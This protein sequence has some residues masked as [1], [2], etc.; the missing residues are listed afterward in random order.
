MASNPE[1]IPAGGRDKISVVVNTE[2]R[3][4]QRL[5]KHFTVMTNDPSRPQVDLIVAG[6]VN[7]YVKV[8]PPYIRLLGRADEDLRT[9][10]QIQP[11]KEHPFTIKKVSAREGENIRYELKPLGAD[12]AQGGYE[13]VVR[14]TRKDTGTYRDFITIETDLKE[15]P[16]LKIPVSGRILE[17]PAG[18]GRKKSK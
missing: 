2:N 1:S 12:P 6:K 3:G 11:Q 10:I 4:G 13:L 5:T 8:M 15:K 14:N 17:P 16:T 7:G 18:A 9:I